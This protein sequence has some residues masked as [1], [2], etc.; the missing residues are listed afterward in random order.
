LPTA[1]KADT[2]AELE[3]LFARSSVAVLTDYRGLTVKELTAM[4]RRLAENDVDYHVAK[5]TLTRIALERQGRGEVA[6]EL[7]GPTAIAFGFGEPSVAPKTLTDY[8]RLNRSIL[9]IKGAILGD[10]LLSAE[11]V[12]GL[13]RLPSKAELQSQLLGALQGPMFGLV[14]AIN[15]LLGGLTTVLQRRVEQLEGET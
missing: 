1:K 14:S 13:A 7:E 8:I 11:E 2:I 5:N 4:R 6:G 10:R 15:Q 3:G 12:E 9:K